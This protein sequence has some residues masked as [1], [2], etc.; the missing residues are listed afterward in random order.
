MRKGDEIM[1]TKEE[2]LE[3][4]IIFLLKRLEKQWPKNCGLWLYANGMQL[5]LMRTHPDG[6]REPVGSKPGSDMDRSLE[7]DHFDIPND[8][9]DW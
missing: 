2:V 6:S 4:R 3:K 5:R 9:G 7:I 8:G 1:S